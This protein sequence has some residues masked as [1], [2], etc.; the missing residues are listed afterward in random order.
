LQSLQSALV[1]IVLT[2]GLSQRAFQQV[3]TQH[4]GGFR[5]CGPFLTVLRFP[6]LCGARAY[7]TGAFFHNGAIAPP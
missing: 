4:G 7:F 5:R 3:E 6:F 2:I 1:I